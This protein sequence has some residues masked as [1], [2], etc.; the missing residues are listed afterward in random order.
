MTTQEQQLLDSQEL[1]VWTLNIPYKSTTLRK[2]AKELG[3]K[4]N[5]TAKVWTVKCKECELGWEELDQCIVKN[6]TENNNLGNYGTGC[7]TT[8][9]KAMRYGYDAIER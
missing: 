3:A 8:R 6:S 7:N 9:E 5:P 1:K 2:R 4:W